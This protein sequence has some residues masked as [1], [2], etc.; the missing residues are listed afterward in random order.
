MP[1]LRA[2]AILFCLFTL[3]LAVASG[4][5][6][7]GPPGH[8][9]GKGNV[10][11][12]ERAPYVEGE[13]LVG[14]HPGT[15]GSERANAR[16]M[17][18]ATRVHTFR[19]GAE[20]WRLGPGV[21]VEQAIE[22]MARNPNVTYA[23]PNYLLTLD[24]IP[25]DPRLDELWGMINTGQ[26]GGTPDA[27]IDADM[28]WGVSTGSS[29]V[30]V[31]VIDTG[32]DYNHPELAANIWT[33]PGEIP[34]NGVDDDGNGYVDDVHG[35][36]FYNDDGDPMDDHGH[37][38]HCSGT[39]GAIGDNGIGV[40]GVNWTVKIMALKFIGAGGSGPTSAAAEAVDYAVMMGADLTS[41]SYGGGAYLQTFYDAIQGAGVANQAFVAAAG[42]DGLNTDVT[43]HYPST[44]DLANIIAVAATDHNDARASFSNYGLTTVDLG[45][46]GVDILSTLPGNSY[47]LGSG[48]SMATPH[49]SG[50]CALIRAV[51]PAIPVAQMKT[52]LLNATDPV[53]SM[54]GRTVSGGR[55]NAFFAIAEPD[56]VEPD[57]IL[58]L[59]TTSPTSNTMGLT[60]TA[61]GDDGSVGTA[62]YYEVRYSTA[63]ID[64]TNWAAATLAGNEPTP[65]PSGSPESME[66]LGLTAGTTYYFAIK[67]FDEWGNISLL[68]NIAVGTTLPPPTG[69]VTP[70]TINEALYTG[71]A[72][73]HTAILSNVG[74]GTLDF[75]IPEPALGSPLAAPEP[76]LILGKDED[77]PRQLP[78]QI[79]GS[80]GPDAFGYR[81][82][83]SDEPGGPAFN[84]IDISGT[85]TPIA[86]LD[87][88]DENA[89]PLPLGFSF[90]FYGNLFN[91]IRVSTNG[92]LSFTSTATTYTNQPLPNSGGP[93]NMIAPFWDDLHFRSVERAYFQ[94]FGYSAI[95]QWQNVD[96]FSTGSDLTFQVILDSSGA[97]TI[98]YLSLSGV[99]DSATV[100]IQNDTKTDG[101][102]V[103]FN[104]AYLH[105]SLAIR[106]AAMPQWLTVTPTSGRLWAGES[107]PLDIGIDASGLEGGT[108]P[109][110]ISIL[111]N[112]PA[113]PTLT[114]DVTLQV[115]GAPD[116]EVS[117]S[118][119]AFGDRFLGLPDSLTLTVLNNG[120]D[121]LH[122]TGIATADPTL[123]VSPSVFDV[124]QH[125]SQDV[126]VTWTPA[127]L[128]PFASS[129]TVFSDDAGEPAI[130]VPVTG[131]A[132][133]APVMITTPSS[134]TETLYSGQTST[135]TLLIRNAGGSDLIVDT[136]AD[137]GAGG[138]GLVIGSGVG[139]E[140]SGGPDNFGY[141]WRDSDESGG[142]I[143]DWVEISGIGTWVQWDADNYCGACN[144]GPFPLGFDFPFYGN[145]FTEVRA[146]VTG[147]LSFTST[148]TTGSNV[149][150]P[151]SGSTY[152]EN[153]LAVFW[154]SLYS[155]NGSGSEP[156][157][158]GAYYYSDGSRFIFQ[159]DTFYRSGDYDAD[160]DFQVILY[161]TGKIVYQYK[162]MANTLLNSAT[163]GIQNATKDDGLTVVYNADYVHDEMAIE[164]SYIPDWLTVTPAHAVIP[165]GAT[166]TFNVNFNATGRF[167]GLL[168]GNVVLSTNIPTQPQVL[169][170]AELT[171]IGAPEATVYPA[172]Y[173][174]GTVYS[175][176]PHLT[177]FQVVNIGTDVLNVTGVISNDPQLFVEVPPGSDS[178]PEAEFPLPPGQAR[179]FDLRWAPTGP[180]TMNAEVHVLSDDPVNPVLVM[181][182]TG[183]AIPPPVAA[184]SPT[185]FAEAMNVGDVIHR[186]LHLE[187]NG[188]SDLE[189]G[190]AFRLLGG[191]PVTVYDE[192]ILEKQGEEID[193]LPDPRPGILG[194][195]GPDLYGYTWKDSDEPGGPIFNW[196]D[197]SG[198]GTQIPFGSAG[199][200]DDC[201]EGPFPI[202]FSFPYYGDT[203]GEVYVSTN[204][205]VSFTSTST[206]YSN[207][208]LPNS[209][210]SVPENLLAVF[211]DDLVHRNGTG[212]EP[213]PSAAYYYNDGTKF[214]VQ[215]Q[216]LYR[217]GDYDN[218]FTFQVILYPS[219]KIRYQYL[220]MV[221]GLLNSATIGQQNAAKDDGLTVAH[222]MDYVHDGL[223]I[224]IRHP[225]D[226][227]SLSP[228]SGTVPPGGYLDLDVTFDTSDLIGGDYFASLDIV[229]NDPAHAYIAIP[230][231]LYVTGIPDI[232]AVPAA[233]TF[234]TTFVGFTSTLDMVVRNVGTDVLH[235][236]ALGVS[237]D[238][239]YT[240]M[241]PGPPLDLPVGGEIPVSVTFAPTSDGLRIGALTVTS[242]DPDEGI[243]T[244]PLEGPGLFPPEIDVSPPSITTALPPGGSRTKMLTVHN[245]GGSDLVWTAG[246]STVTT[247]GE[248]VFVYPAMEFERDEVDPRPGILGSGGPDAFGYTWKDSDEPGGPT[249]DWVEISGIGTEIIFTSSGYC[250]DCFTGPF[251]L[252]MSFPFYGNSFTEFW[253]TSEGYI[254]FTEITSPDWSN[255]PLPSAGAPSNL[256]AL[257]WDDLVLRSGTGSEPVRSAAYYHYD[258]TRFILQW[259]NFYRIADY[260]TDFTFQLILYPNGKIVY[261]YETMANAQLDSATIGIQNETRDDGLTV[262]YNAPYM[263]DGLAIE[264]QAGPDWLLVDPLSGVIPAGGSQDVTVFLN[265]AGLPDGIHEATIDFSSNDPYTP[266]MNVPVTL[267]V[268]LVEP[269]Y[270]DFEP[271][272]LNLSSSGNTVKVTVQLPAGLD[273]RAVDPCSVLLN[274]TVPV[275]GCPGTPPMGAVEY[276]DE[277][278]MGGDGIEEVS[279][280]FDRDAVNA[281]L[282]EGS[283]VAVY[284]QGEVA[285]VQWWRGMTSI[286]TLR[287]NVTSPA[288]AEYFIDGMLV[289]IRWTEP[290]WGSPMTY[291]I[292]LSRDG[293]NTW[294][295]LASGLTGTQ[296]DWVAGGG[297]TAAAKV[298]V[299]AFDDVGLVGY[300]TSDGHFTL[301]GPVLLPPRAVDGSRMAVGY[302]ASSLTIW[303]EWPPA[304]LAHG[305]ATGFRILTAGQPGGAY[306]EV[307]LVGNTQYVD[308]SGDP[309]P[310]QVRFFRV[311]ATN[312]AGDAQ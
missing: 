51:S 179:L 209:G 59:A 55:L 93:E 232:E 19:S 294:E 256:V 111:T 74:L 57:P 144:V 76:P 278:P 149:A 270:V 1:R 196:V 66:V 112:D 36:D 293:G 306:T 71:Q 104:Q 147:W 8:L 178:I 14:F 127:V 174:Y 110:T 285:D 157:A 41:N 145:T 289:P 146:S 188:G 137:Q 227:L 78:P 37:G 143:Y 238:Y 28:A 9:E 61:T 267:N 98:Q 229:T 249:Y 32:V 194:A 30:L 216:N 245:N 79:L 90:P 150:L 40:A 106:I 213:V 220:T 52:V 165:A 254:T 275:V 119:L 240:V 120:T 94:S 148:K 48:T 11:A 63:P 99:L 243:L 139:T 29:S 271:D 75:T 193:A 302:D 166:E 128:G 266:M 95:V 208:P 141:R 114:I 223:A 198:V 214:I 308:A 156:V 184:W 53:A 312:A 124:V 160:L 234:P 226:F 310:G 299:L 38:T 259:D 60:W 244:V 153:L 44:Y 91:S 86:G 298:R 286:R 169:L 280:R 13:I 168:T 265:A 231:A 199:Y 295:E 21:R 264:I 191:T 261:Q 207:Q 176:Y 47:G 185:S 135:Q 225:F 159:Y 4:P 182:V 228:P 281:I 290:T 132:I 291:T 85:G 58:D 192:L 279:F 307:A 233:L 89:G 43:P 210:S 204:G 154:D 167:G 103:A 283:S 303:W 239:S 3:T 22:R 80:G 67:A 87:G 140:G 117:P 292:H 224:E 130:V 206:T 276:T 195:G 108:Y 257:F 171:V 34:G 205:W 105:D 113:H 230:I 121:V 164:I 304:D 54:Q 23:E 5:N 273:P 131:N 181:P 202:G 250:M 46:P 263:H 277:W 50:V 158:S 269:D 115:T 116:A 42:N 274:D 133:P 253:V 83:D 62:S 187:N 88:D 301:A 211:W 16:A 151:N 162:T 27:D 218:D 96:R 15:R 287:P 251:P 101:L 45:A 81:W 152:P 235:V 39:I 190:S 252:G 69:S 129:L 100:G 92:W 236:A 219:G 64:D 134:F 197:I 309:P 258:G 201:N 212:S 70:T 107:I 31:A 102:T 200:C 138:T 7:G 24:I 305:P 180:Y 161:P 118:A 142:P 246:T 177:N 126:T 68:S 297:V 183:V 300:D 123:S 186:T 25:N 241:P 296:F 56:D 284:I 282:G 97:I 125:S 215:F 170:P 163:I 49:V 2:F 221:N 189:F 262:V 72:T 20:H 17:V 6:Q 73:A 203:F 155:R 172:S 18:Q 217:L 288:P 175:G 10:V 173:D 268:S 82:I 26:T 33:N 12:D 35:Y 247:L 109:G 136:A 77:D 255:D 242:D 122:V 84:W 260:D 311:V 65:S 237:G 222:N 248:P 272:V